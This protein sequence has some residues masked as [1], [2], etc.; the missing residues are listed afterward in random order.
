MGSRIKKITSSEKNLKVARKSIVASKNINK[1]E[2][3]TKYN[4][5]IKRPGSGLS[6][7]KCIKF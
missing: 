7:M 6:P 2:K 4:L 5:S 3:F 1:G